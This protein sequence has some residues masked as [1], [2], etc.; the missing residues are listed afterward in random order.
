MTNLYL[1]N[2]ERTH[3]IWCMFSEPA[4]DG[5]DVRIVNLART[6]GSYGPQRDFDEDRLRD[7]RNRRAHGQD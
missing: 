3:K 4:G 5:S 2:P 1:F 6:D 7:L